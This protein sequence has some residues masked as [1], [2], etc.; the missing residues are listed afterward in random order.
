LSKNFTDL[1]VIYTTGYAKDIISQQDLQ[2]EEINLISKPYNIDDLVYKV[3]KVL[4]Q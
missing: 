3:R 4:D 2:H 1:K